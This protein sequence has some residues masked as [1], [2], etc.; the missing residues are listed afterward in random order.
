M[1]GRGEVF[2]TVLGTLAEPVACL[3]AQPD[4]IQFL[5]CHVQGFGEDVPDGG[6]T[7]VQRAVGAVQLDHQAVGLGVIGGSGVAVVAVPEH[8]PADALAHL[9][10]VA[11]V[12]MAGNSLQQFLGGGELFQQHS[13]ALCGACRQKACPPAFCRLSGKQRLKPFSAAALG[14]LCRNGRQLCAT[15]AL[16]F[17]KA[18]Q[19]FFVMGFPAA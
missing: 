8:A 4:G 18:T 2:Q 19:R 6:E 1:T 13:T 12:Q 11:D 9:T 10:A 3:T 15:V 7:A 16:H 14:K 5:Q 17:P